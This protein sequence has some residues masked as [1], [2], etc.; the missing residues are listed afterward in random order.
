MAMKTSKRGGF[1]HTSHEPRKPI[2]VDT[3][4]QNAVE[5]TSSIFVHHDL[6]DSPNEQWRKKDSLPPVKSQHPREE[7]IRCY[8]TEVLHQCEESN[9]VDG[10]W[11]GGD[12][13]FG[14]VKSCIELKKHCKVYSNF[15]I[16]QNVNYFP[17]QVIH[18]VLLAS[19]ESKPVSHRVIIQMTTAGAELFVMA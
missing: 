1:R 16:K 7:E 18:K 2:P 19:H 10:G 9:V 4:M 11:V 12:A 5:C 3:M 17:M 8:C 13:W 14:L 6:V 15:I